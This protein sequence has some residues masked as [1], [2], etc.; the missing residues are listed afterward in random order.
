MNAARLY[1]IGF[2][3]LVSV[4]PPK[5]ELAPVT[6][7][8]P[9]SRG[10]AS[11]R[12]RLDGKWVGYNFIEADYPS[13][14]DVRQWDAW[15]AN[16]GLWA[17]KYPGL[18]IDIDEEEKAREVAEAALRI[19]GDAPVRRSTQGRRL[20]VYRTETPFPEFS[21]ET[22][23]G[24]VEV[25]SGRRQYLVLGRH[26]SGNDY[27]Y[28]GKPLWEWPPDELTSVTQEQFREFLAGLGDVGPVST[29]LAADVDQESL[30]APSMSDL[31]RIVNR[32]PND[33]D[34]D[35]YIRMG[36]AIKAA[37]GKEALYIW[38]DWCAT[39]TDGT[40]DPTDVASDWT[41]FKPPFR[42]GWPWLQEQ[43]PA[44]E[45]F[46]ADPDQPQPEVVP[47]GGKLRLFNAEGFTTKP[48]PWLWE[49]YIPQG[50]ITLLVGDPGLGKSM[51]TVRLSALATR[52]ELGGK[53]TSVVIA[54][55]EDSWEY[56]VRPRLEAAGADL[57]RVYAPQV[58][59]PEFPR[60]VLLPDDVA[61]L[62]AAMQQHGAG[63]LVIDP[64][65][66]HLGNQTDSHN[67]KSTRSALAPLHKLAERTGAAVIGVMH[68]NKAQ[69]DDVIR[70]VGGSIGFVGLARS[71]I[72]WTRDPE[73]ENEDKPDRIMTHAKTNVGEMGPAVR[74]RM[75][76]VNSGE[77]KTARVVPDGE[78][79][80]NARQALAGK[81]RSKRGS[82]KSW[83][84]T[85]LAG[86]DVPVTE[87]KDGAASEGYSWSTVAVAKKELPIQSRRVGGV[88]EKGF[89]IWSLN[90]FEVNDEGH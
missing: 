56:V 90:E 61:A 12:R 43:V 29:Q 49:P 66:A 1:D 6:S 81:S 82:V 65:V 77:I 70:R 46:T 58:G 85:V 32:I 39:W 76:P 34:R 38:A 79:K 11:G 78:S 22:E 23:G 5:A 42:I 25:L 2:E 31:A 33:V 41:T 68:L 24:R 88:G 48:V 20:L 36:H 14:N 71:I 30:K 37:G 44:T 54:T 3:E 40:N 57:S 62:S 80:V 55:A 28:D 51:L 67:D 17:L 9:K 60:G 69:V 87:L 73:D 15:G 13:L 64:L 26:P 86:G 27:H 18:D 7:V 72:L 59:N 75:E 19:L 89:W 83:L 53:P 10:K 45:E 35:G 21:V 63:L 74:Y 4:I 47:D 52:G 84:T 16:V 8:K 50:M